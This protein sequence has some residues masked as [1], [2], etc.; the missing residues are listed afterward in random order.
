[1][2]SKYKRNV[3][4]SFNLTK[5]TCDCKWI[6]DNWLS[7]PSLRLPGG[8]YLPNIFSNDDSVDVIRRSDF[9]NQGTQGTLH[10]PT[11]ISQ[12]VPCRKENCRYSLRTCSYLQADKMESTF[13]CAQHSWNSLFNL[14]KISNLTPL[15]FENEWVRSSLS[16]D[17]TWG[18]E[19][20]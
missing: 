7:R 5:I 9:R 16:L 13:D 15:K 3:E 4:P 20:L 18:T 8:S 17:T 6:W 12:R 2:R 1:M 10:E 14:E 19:I 11:N